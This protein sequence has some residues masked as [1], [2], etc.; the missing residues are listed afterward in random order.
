M[1]H[2][3]SSQLLREARHGSREAINAV[4]ERYG[5]RLHA[6][7]RVRLGP[8][9]RRRLESRDILQET[10]L[11]AFRGIDRFEGSGSTSLMA[12]L[13]TI[14]RDEICDQADFYGRQKRD[15]ARDT[16]LDERVD[17]VADQIR[18]EASRLQLQEDSERL[19]KA[20]DAL[21]EPYREV[22]LLRHFEELSFRD[23]GERLA[24]SPDAC[25]MLLARAMTAL[26]L[27]MRGIS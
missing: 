15:A 17:G 27:K 2:Q 19:E 14:A 8:H 16:S 21:S 23:I 4:F 12:W 22:I 9:L 3:E 18:S 25:R 13:G 26:T 10:L 6:L 20:L 24:K 7:I 1:T 5:E 11:K